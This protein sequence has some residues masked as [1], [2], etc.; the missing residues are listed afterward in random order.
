[1]IASVAYGI[2]A[3]SLKNPDGDFRR[4]G[5][6]LF[7]ASFKRAV[8]FTSVFF[9]PQIIRLVDAKFFTNSQSKFL[10]STIT[11]V[12]ELREQSGVFRNDLID[13]LLSFKK[14]NY[15]LD[16]IV[17]QA[18]V[19][20]TAGFETTSSVMSFALY[21]LSKNQDVQDKL[22]AEIKES[23]ANN[24]GE[25]SYEIINSME[26]LKVVV[27][28]VL[29][30][31]PPLPFLDR[32]CKLPNGESGYKLDDKLEIPNKMP[33]FIP[34]YSIQRDPKYFKEPNTFM[35]E[36]FSDGNKSNQ[37]N[38]PFGIGPHN[39]IGERFGLMQA[40]I[41]LISFLKNHKVVANEKTAKE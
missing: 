5:R 35:P 22:R 16:M 24:N 18:A 40:K 25:I 9:L 26:Y 33:I 2:E 6:A 4:N 1:V 32:E 7:K 15:P 34:I 12:M 19:F 37:A 14:Q 28:E 30:M 27:Q 29:R 21:E 23:L 17:A 39:C 20:F 41:G 13:V 38:M 3:N 36:R 8:D 11:H 31:Y 10:Y